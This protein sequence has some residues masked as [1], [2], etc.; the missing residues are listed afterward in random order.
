[1]VDLEGWQAIGL[2]CHNLEE[3]DVLGCVELKGPGLQGLC[4]GCS[5]LSRLH[6]CD[7]NNISFPAVKMFDSKRPNVIRRCYS[8]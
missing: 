7:R 4:D 5:K 1:M 3:L 6:I 8:F 2:N